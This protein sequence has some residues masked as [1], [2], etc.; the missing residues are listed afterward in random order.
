[1]TAAAFIHAAAPGWSSSPVGACLFFLPTTRLLRDATTNLSPLT[2]NRIG[3]RILGGYYCF[4]MRVTM[5][6]LA[7][8]PLAR[9]IE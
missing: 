8:L 7:P 6:P 5:K 3:K 4:S 2:G 9:L 1:M